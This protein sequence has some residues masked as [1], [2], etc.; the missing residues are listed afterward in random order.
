MFFLPPS[1]F[2]FK[3]AFGNG[4]ALMLKPAGRKMK[5]HH[6]DDKEIVFMCMWTAHVRSDENQLLG[7]LAGLLFNSENMSKRSLTL[8]K[9]STLSFSFPQDIWCTLSKP[10]AGEHTED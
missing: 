2:T 9:K 3:M 6:C 10:P 4:T 5:I 1:S 8:K 7:M